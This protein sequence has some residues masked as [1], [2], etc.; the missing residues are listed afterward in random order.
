[1]LLRWIFSLKYKHNFADDT[2][3]PVFAPSP[4]AINEMLHICDEY[5]TEFCQYVFLLHPVNVAI[6]Y[7]TPIN[8]GSVYD[9]VTQQI[10][11]S[12]VHH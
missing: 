10:F 2:V 7:V 11:D 6:W 4:F 12:F 5:T 9:E 1:M 3:L 8:A